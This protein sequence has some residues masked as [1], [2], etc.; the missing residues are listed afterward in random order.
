MWPKNSAAT[1]SAAEQ[2]EVGMAIKAVQFFTTAFPE[3]FKMYLDGA[4]T[5]KAIADKMRVTLLAWRDPDQVKAAVAQMAPLVGA[6]PQ[7][8]GALSQGTPGPAA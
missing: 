5:M 1:T 2:Q 3:E 8:T 7:N 4:K 6:R